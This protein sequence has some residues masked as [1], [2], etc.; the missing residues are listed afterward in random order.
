M[1]YEAVTHPPFLLSEMEPTRA[2]REARTL[3][4]S[5][6]TPFARSSSPRSRALRTS[7]VFGRSGTKCLYVNTWPNMLS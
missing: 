7:A 1:K 4:P 3:I 2:V 5:A 6:T